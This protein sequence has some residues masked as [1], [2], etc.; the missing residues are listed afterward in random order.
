VRAAWSAGI[1]QVRSVISGGQSLLAAIGI[2]VGRLSW[3]LV[4]DALGVRP[5]SSVSPLM[6]AI[7][8]ATLCLALVLAIVPVR[9]AATIQPAQTLRSD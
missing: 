6:L 2:V 3:Q 8:P 1:A 9:R 7:V 5:V 4:A